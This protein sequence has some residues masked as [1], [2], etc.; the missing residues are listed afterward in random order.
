[1]KPL[2]YGINYVLTSCIFLLLWT[3]AALYA[4]IPVPDWSARLEPFPVGTEIA[5]GTLR[6]G[7]TTFLGFRKTETGVDTLDNQDHI[8][9]IGS[10]TKTFTTYVYTAAL[11]DGRLRSD[12]LLSDFF[13][14]PLAGGKKVEQITLDQ[15]A[16]HSSGI[17]RL[18]KAWLKYVLQPQPYA[19]IDSAEIAKVLT[20]TLKLNHDPGTDYEYS[21]FA[22]GVLAEILED[23][24]AF[25]LDYLI[26]ELICAPNGMAD[27]RFSIADSSRWISG[28]NSSGQPVVPWRFGSLKGAGALWSTTTDMLKFLQFQLGTDPAVL[29]GQ[30]ITLPV[31][32]HLSVARGW[33]YYDLAPESAPFYWHNGATLGYRSFAGFQRGGK[34][35]AVVILSNISAFS[36]YMSDVDEWGR[37]FFRE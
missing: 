14:Y 8:F 18:P 26:E 1:M 4:Q 33:H 2:P 17:P 23:T 16:N 24:F 15:L 30:E 9:R 20:K 5:I 21:N 29:W 13:P 36:P 32:E 34:E 7:A 37:A 28:L 19:H 27:T 25:P 22:I 6:N 3:H 12:D 11:E 31:F 35:K 10:V